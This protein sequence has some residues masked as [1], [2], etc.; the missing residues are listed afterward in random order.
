VT[1]VAA[2]RTSAK[3]YTK[4]AR[5]SSATAEATSL[6]RQVDLHEGQKRCRSHSPEPPRTH[7]PRWRTRARSGQENALPLTINSTCR[8]HRYFRP[9]ACASLDTSRQSFKAAAAWPSRLLARQARA[10]LGRAS[11]AP[12]APAAALAR[13][14]FSCSATCAISDLAGTGFRTPQRQS[15]RR[16]ARAGSLC[17]PVPHRTHEQGGRPLRARS[18]FSIFIPTQKIPVAGVGGVEVGEHLARRTMMK[19]D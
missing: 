13:A 14:R 8:P 18:R 2:S 17:S 9:P 7:Q 5:N 6:S 10:S 15:D 16:S 12:G 1:F 19:P 11:A 4:Y 3:R